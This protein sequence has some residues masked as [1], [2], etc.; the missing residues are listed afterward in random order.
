MTVACTEDQK[1]RFLKPFLA[2][3]TCLL[4]GARIREILD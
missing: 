3:D 4:G 1:E 2:D